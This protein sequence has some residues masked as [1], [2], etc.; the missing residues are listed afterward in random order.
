LDIATKNW[1]IFWSTA[2]T[3]DGALLKLPMIQVIAGIRHRSPSL[4]H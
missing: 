1:D 3:L 4:Y 2:A